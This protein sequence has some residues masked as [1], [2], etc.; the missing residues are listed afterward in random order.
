MRWPAANTW[1]AVAVRREREE[2]RVRGRGE[3]REAEE[4]KHAGLGGRQRAL[5]EKEDRQSV[6]RGRVRKPFA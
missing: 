1:L 5:A 2:E 4:E 6:T 3:E